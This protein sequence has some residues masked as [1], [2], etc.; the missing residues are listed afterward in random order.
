MENG[1]GE[2]TFEGDKIHYDISFDDILRLKEIAIIKECFKGGLI[3]GNLHQK[4]G[5][6]IFQP[7]KGDKI[8][9]VGELEG[10]EYVTSPKTTSKYREEI[11]SIN[12]D[13]KTSSRYVNTEFTIPKTCKIVDLSGKKNQLIILTHFNQFVINRAAAKKHIHRIIELD[14]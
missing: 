12:N 4:G 13:I 10:W 6:Q 5:I 14:S 8:R 9:H 1:I 3:L 7:I 11:V 2:H